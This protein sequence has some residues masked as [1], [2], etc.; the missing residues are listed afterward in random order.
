MMECHPI[1][2]RSPMGMKDEI[3]SM[4]I[5]HN[6]IKI[7]ARLVLIPCKAL[8]SRTLPC[9]ALSSQVIQ[10]KKMPAST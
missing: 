6:S 7:S 1:T 2:Q 4:L 3:I 10:G 9:K 5:P 8:L